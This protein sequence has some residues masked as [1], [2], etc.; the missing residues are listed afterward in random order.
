MPGANAVQLGK[1]GCPK[2]KNFAS[3]NTSLKARSHYN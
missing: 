1:L 3:V 2:K